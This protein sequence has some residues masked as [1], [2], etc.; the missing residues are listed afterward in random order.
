MLFRKKTPRSCTTCLFA[1]DLSEDTL[2]CSKRGVVK[3]TSTC[4][5]YRYDHCKLITPCVKAHDFT[6][7]SE[8]D[9]KLD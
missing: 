4:T 7:Y 9:F 8:E 6:K 1:T 3:E 5:K 2:L